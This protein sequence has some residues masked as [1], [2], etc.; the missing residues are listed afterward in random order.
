MYGTI[1]DSM[2]ARGRASGIMQMDDLLRIG[3]L[4]YDR[5][6]ELEAQVLSEVR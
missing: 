6:A 5:K 1:G 4:E 2:S 3:H